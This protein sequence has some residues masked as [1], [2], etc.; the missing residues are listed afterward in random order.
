MNLIP[1]LSLNCSV[2]SHDWEVIV[3]RGVVGPG[4]GNK[5]SH[6]RE[7]TPIQ[8][9]TLEYNFD[10]CEPVEECQLVTMI[11]EFLATYGNEN[12]TEDKEYGRP[13]SCDGERI[14]TMEDLFLLAL[15]EIYTKCVL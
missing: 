3:A 15:F 5:V 12:K 10:G 11:A 1:C 4:P 6:D 9:L 7:V 14:E 2:L 13:G 8:Q